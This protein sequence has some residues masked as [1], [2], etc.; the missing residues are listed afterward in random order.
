MNII[1]KY[2]MNNKNNNKIKKN[3]NN[4]KYKKIRQIIFNDNIY[5]DIQQI[6]YNKNEK[7]HINYRSTIKNIR[8]YWNNV[9]SLFYS[10]YESNKIY[11]TKDISKTNNIL[12]NLYNYKF[13]IYNNENIHHNY[14]NYKNYDKDI[15][16]LDNDEYC[17]S[18]NILKISKIS[19]YVISNI[20]LELLVLYLND[21]VN[22]GIFCNCDI[23]DVKFNIIINHD[24]VNYLI[25]IIYTIYNKLNDNNMLHYKY[26]NF[27]DIFINLFYY[28]HDNIF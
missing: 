13:S 5:I 25:K 14:Y 17:I 22:F 27:N 10:T 1:N 24:Y 3:V 21:N 2:K 26:N 23:I 9:N 12:D 4:G 15:S 8:D 7:Q 28:K 16:K 20:L 18:F 19:T 11:I 6:I